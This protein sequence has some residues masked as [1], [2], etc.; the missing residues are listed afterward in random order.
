MIISAC[1]M[2]LTVLLSDTRLP[3]S[4]MTFYDKFWTIDVEVRDPDCFKRNKPNMLMPRY[5]CKLIDGSVYQIQTKWQ[6]FVIYT[7]H[8]LALLV[9]VF[10]YGAL[11]YM[12]LIPDVFKILRD[13]S[14]ERSGD[15]W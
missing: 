8:M 4:N 2:L 12:N 9:V 15:W 1:L 14:K 10:A 13:K 5:R 7:K 11:R 3:L 6:S